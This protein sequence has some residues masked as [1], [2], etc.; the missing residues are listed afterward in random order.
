MAAG[1]G[2][3]SEMHG[4]NGKKTKTILRKLVEKII[5]NL[6]R[7]PGYRLDP[8]YSSRQLFYI[9]LYR[10]FQI[11]RGFMIKY[12]ISSR[13]ITFCG[14]RVIIEHGYLLSAGRSLILEDGVHI[15]ALSQDGI[16]FG[17]HVTIA[18]YAILNCTGVVASK[19]KG[20]V[21]GHNSAVGAQ[22]FLG[23]QG[24][25]T[26]GDNVI[27][28]PQVKIFSENHR[29]A[30]KGQ[31]IRTQG[32]SRRGVVVGNDC[33]IGAGATIMDGV[34]IGS[35]CVVAAGAVVTRSVPDYGVVMGVPAKF[36]KSRN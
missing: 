25:I 29:Y 10:F 11:C 33:W 3:G 31:L 14:R 13:G 16:R 36:M 30:I 21:I 34:V 19:G 23:G 24:G 6:K 20:I 28:G 18:R 17:D 32:E 15:N 5:A 12:K 7:D 27:M 1:C 8:N 26:I 9:V 22:S 2:G 4:G 35:G